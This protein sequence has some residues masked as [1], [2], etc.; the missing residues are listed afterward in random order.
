MRFSM[1]TA[2]F[3]ILLIFAGVARAQ[4]VPLPADVWPERAAVNGQRGVIHDID[5]AWLTRLRLGRTLRLT[6]GPQTA[7]DAKALGV[8]D[9][10][11]EGPNALVYGTTD[12]D[13]VLRAGLPA[14]LFRFASATPRGAVQRTWFALF[15]PEQAKGV[16]VMLP[17]MLG[18]PAGL[19]DRLAEQLLAADYAVL[20]M[21]A[22][23][24][25][26]T[27]T[28]DLAIGPDLDASARA[29][30]EVLQN[31]VGEA[32]FAVDAALDHV[33]DRMPELSELPRA[34]IGM[35]GGAMI[36]PTVLALD[37]GDWSGAIMIAGGAN[38][39]AVHDRSNYAPFI[40]AFQQR[41]VGLEENEANRALFS[42]AYLD[43]APID[44]FHAARAVSGIPWLVFQGEFDRAVPAELGELVWEQLGR[45][46]RWTAPVGHELLFLFLPN[47]Y[48]DMVAWLDRT[49]GFE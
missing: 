27:E 9:P 1:P 36:L 41:W 33:S 34:A 10:T 7:Q 18:T 45:P 3:A 40:G 29:V 8:P 46:E 11:F 43:A 37:P 47:R 22:H 28:A 25:R 21:M 38:F 12:Q 20:R 4:P 26:F 44:S 13:P 2:V 19:I 24:S 39:W 31:R 42:A 32:A 49:L 35:S 23:P 48:G 5:A 17:G 30:A 6:D 16:V 15:T 14:M